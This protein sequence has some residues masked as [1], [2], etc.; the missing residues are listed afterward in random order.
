M[1]KLVDFEKEQARQHEENLGAVQGHIQNLL[2]D[3]NVTI[4]EWYDLVQRINQSHDE[5]IV[6][7][8][9]NEIRER[10]ERP[11]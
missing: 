4:K 9:I 7:I 6:N 11:V 10:Y 8:S 2:A 5:V 1:A 3:H